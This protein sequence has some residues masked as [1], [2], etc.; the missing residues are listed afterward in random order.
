MKNVIITGG[1]G[2]VG[3]SLTRMVRARF[4]DC[5]I[6]A[7]GSRDVDLADRQETFRFFEKARWTNKCDHIIHLAALYKAG[8]WPVHH[9]ATQFYVNMSINVNV[10]EAWRT[11]F[12]AAKLTSILS[13]CVY[14]SH[15]EPHGEGEIYNSEPE[16]YLFAYA[17]T[18]KCLLIGQKAYA[19]EHGLK[20]TSVALPTVYGPGDSFLENSHVVGALIGKFVRASQHGAPTVEVWGDGLQEREFLYVDD[21]ADGIIAAALRSN[22]EFMNLGAGTAHSIRDIAE[23]IARL[24]GF[25]G[26]IVQNP[27]KFTGVACRVLNVDLMRE[28]LGWSAQTKLEEG[29]KRTIAAYRR[30]LGGENSPLTE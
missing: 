30:E 2:F 1:T 14:P 8:D 25:N 21:A 7:L 6:M 28:R 26:R 19:R 22:E 17:Y 23:A 27:T 24:S 13:Y 29:L 15:S 5:E 20:S 12:P 3:K 4:P 9:Q 10:L 18:K 11:F 16:D